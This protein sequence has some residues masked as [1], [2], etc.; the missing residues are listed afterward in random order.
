MNKSFSII[1]INNKKKNYGKT[2]IGK[3][4][5]PKDAAYKLFQSYM[6]NNNN[7]RNKITFKIQENTSNSKKKIYGNYI[8]KLIKKSQNID[9]KKKIIY[10]PVIQIS[11]K[12]KVGGDSYPKLELPSKQQKPY[13]NSTNTETNTEPNTESNNTNTETNT[14]PNTESNNTN[15]IVSTGPNNYKNNNRIL[16]NNFELYYKIKDNHLNEVK[17]EFYKKFLSNS[18]ELFYYIFE[19]K[20]KNIQKQRNF[21]LTR[22]K[23]PSGYAKAI[24]IPTRKDTLNNKKLNYYSI[25]GIQHCKRNS[26]FSTKTKY[27]RV[28]L[29]NVTYCIDGD[30]SDLIIKIK[31]NDNFK[32]GDVVKMEGT[33]YKKQSY[34]KNKLFKTENININ[35]NNDTSIINL[36]NYE[37]EF[38]TF[39]NMITSQGYKLPA[40]NNYIKYKMTPID[41]T[42]SKNEMKDDNHI[43]TYVFNKNKKVK[44]IYNK[45]IVREQVFFSKE[46]I[47][48]INSNTNI[49]NP[50]QALKL[51]NDYKLIIYLLHNFYINVPSRGDIPNNLPKGNKRIIQLYNE[52]NSE[53][54]ISL[55]KENKKKYDNYKKKKKSL[56]INLGYEEL[57]FDGASDFDIILRIKTNEKVFIIG[58]THGSFHSFYRIFLRLIKQKFLDKNLKLLNGN[59]II[60][61]GDVLDRGN[62]AIEILYIILILMKINN[63]DQELNVI[64]N[65]G[66]HEDIHQYSRYGFTNEMELKFNGK[67]IQTPIINL[68]KVL[69]TAIILDHKNTRYWLC[70]G[71]FPWGYNYIE[72]QNG[73]INNKMRKQPKIDTF[74]FNENY[75]IFE[76][77]KGLP[78]QLHI[79]WNDFVNTL[80]S[81]PS[82]RGPSYNKKNGIKPIMLIGLK[83][84]YNFLDKNN[85]DFIIRG[86]EDNNCNSWLLVD[87]SKGYYNKQNKILPL[88]FIEAYDF[89]EKCKFNECIK[90][91]YEMNMNKYIKKSNGPFCT[92]NTKQL[93]KKIINNAKPINHI[94]NSISKSNDKENYKFN[95]EQ[96]PDLFHPVLTISTNSDIGRTLYNDSYVI[97]S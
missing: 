93:K 24:L 81:G 10:I 66:N 25:N 76:S 74:K 52:K 85:I 6:N 91:N 12:N 3:N 67:N 47:K 27:F 90:Y 80:E 73:K 54:F 36:Y 30:S 32:I 84:L 70:H 7:N 55:L 31:H 46:L 92:I 97:L 41:L 56:V 51:D 45:N 21:I 68:F 89:V 83:D 44:P 78:S 11:R 71:G 58:D 40:N 77:N 72:D 13:T 18:N 35:K 86:H 1:E 48:I 69:S 14:E 95:T 65:K 53:I 8:G 5:C 17:V 57:P 29:D 87:K 38:K 60:I 88:T 75:D 26:I 39:N 4:Q 22:K 19:I 61:L 42:L 62:F 9:N 37:V 82:R 50:I 34:N 16:A 64:F 94:P 49:V 59:K 63:S 23:E 33:K 2:F 15:S 20:D 79:R 28:V 96:I 43:L